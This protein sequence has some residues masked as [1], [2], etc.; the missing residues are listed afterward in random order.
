MYTIRYHFISH[1]VLILF[2]IFSSSVY[3]QVGDIQFQQLTIEDG[4]ANSTVKCIIQDQKGFIWFA[5]LNAL[6]RYDGYEFKIYE[7][8][9]LN[10]SSLC[11]DRITC[12][13]EY[14]DG[15]LIAGTL[16]MGLEVLDT[17]TG[18]VSHFVYDKMD[19]SSIGGNAVEDIFIDRSDR[20]WIA[21]ANVLNLFD[22]NTGTFERFTLDDDDLI[23]GSIIEMPD[24]ALWICTSGLKMFQFNLQIKSFEPLDIIPP[25]H[26]NPLIFRSRMFLDSKDILWIC[27]VINGLYRYDQRTGKLENFRYNSRD[28]HSISHDDVFEMIEDDE[29]KYWIATDGGGVSYFNYEERKFYRI[30]HNPVN[31]ASLSSNKS[32]CIFKDNTNIIW[33]GAFSGGVSIYDKNREKFNSYTHDP[34]NS[35]SLSHNVIWS[36]LVDHDGDLWVGTDN[37]GLNLYAPD[38]YGNQFIRFLPNASDPFGISSR[39]VIS[40]FQDSRKLIWLGTYHNGLIQYDKQ[41][42]KFR[43]I[44]AREDDLNSPYYPAGNDVWDIAEDSLGQLWL[45]TLRY[46]V[47]VFHPDMNTFKHYR[48]E[49]SSLSNNGVTNLYVDSKNRIWIGTSN[50]LNLY[51]HEQDD[52]IWITSDIEESNSLAG[53]NIKVITEDSQGNIWLGTEGFGLSKMNPDNFEVTNY[54]D[55]NGLLSNVV[56]SIIEDSK[57]NL[58]IGTSKGISNFNPVKETFRNY[59]K[60]KQ[61]LQSNEFKQKSFAR[62]DDGTFYF[63]GIHGFISFHPDSIKENKGLPPVVITEFS[64]SNKLIDVRS[65]NSPLKQDIGN[66]KEIRLSYKQNIFAFRYSALN[67][68][69]P[70]KNQYAYMLEGFDKEWHYVGSQR[71]A[72]YTNINPGD[73]I[74]RVKASNNDGYWN[75][76]GT[77]IQIIIT[78]P[79]YQTLWFKF[80]GSL[81]IVLAIW[82]IFRARMAGM[83]KRTKQLES[84]NTEL[85]EQ[86]HERKVA[87]QKIQTQLTEKNVL[88]KE[89]HHRVKNNLQIIV[90]LL[91][92]QSAKI[93]NK[94]IQK[95]LLDSRE[96]VSSMA[97]VHERLYHTENLAEIDFSEYIPNLAQELVKAYQLDTQSID[98]NIQCEPVSLAIDYAV[99]CGLILNE[100]ISNAFKHAFPSD[101]D[102]PRKV[103]IALNQDEDGILH[104]LVS[105]NGIGFPD[106]FDPKESDSLGLKLVYILIEDQLNGTVILNKKN[107]TE[108]H[109]QFL[110]N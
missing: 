7:H 58:W 6:N 98:I 4:L 86:I 24:D 99:P 66:T 73:Y 68:T 54:S 102:Q 38:K 21:A 74:F 80:V 52:F 75:E 45:A 5:T 89:I 76:E 25:K 104:L 79:F 97:L 72:N 105:D 91:R 85:N 61:G 46:G 19:E 93:D 101:W 95:I 84:M 108:Y 67:Y 48:Q 20:I 106:N 62:S 94:E 42:Q 60:F 12:L 90:S 81:C 17:K 11:G 65:E 64:L 28:S 49:N 51:D 31:P 63:G 103:S 40:L 92:L 100:L 2:L 109:L 88:L 13:S 10:P 34:N 47:D 18:N 3:S 56:Y 57:G 37:G 83:V 30:Q 70:D 23:I 9:P 69:V 43:S 55:N 44:L 36:L 22:K 110:L 15:D 1:F 53:K 32:F 78:P 35:K 107:G 16:Q 39:S 96:R 50:G 71:F 82:G 26:I 29:G 41:N 59:T 8:D 77:S 27:S 87:E 14:K 33:V